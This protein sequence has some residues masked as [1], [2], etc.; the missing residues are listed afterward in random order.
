MPFRFVIWNITFEKQAKRQPNNWENIQLSNLTKLPYTNLWN[1]NDEAINLTRRHLASHLMPRDWRPIPARFTAWI[2]FWSF[3]RFTVF[4]FHF[5][6]FVK[7]NICAFS[8]LSDCFGRESEPVDTNDC[9]DYTVWS[10]LFF[11]NNHVRFWFCVVFAAL[12]GRIPC[13]PSRECSSLALAICIWLNIAP[14]LWNIHTQIHLH[15]RAKAALRVGALHLPDDVFRWICRAR[16]STRR[17][18][19]ARNYT[20]GRLGY[21]QGEFWN[22]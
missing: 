10:S 7:F 8:I 3:F 1:G 6:V 17:R 15:R 16:E 13:H 18:G 4:F 19:F 20:E 2:R 9:R 22:V 14:W 12:G 5:T 11:I 21:G